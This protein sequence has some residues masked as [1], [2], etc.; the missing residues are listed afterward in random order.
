MPIPSEMLC[1]FFKDSVFIAMYNKAI[2]TSIG[3]KSKITEKK[4]VSPEIPLT[5]FPVLHISVLLCMKYDIFLFYKCL[6]IRERAQSHRLSFYLSQM[7][8]FSYFFVSVNCFPCM[9]RN[10]VPFHLGYMVIF[11]QISMLILEYGSIHLPWHPNVTTSLC[12]LLLVTP[13]AFYSSQSLNLLLWL[14]WKCQQGCLPSPGESS[15]L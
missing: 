14:Q 12:H 2:S 11:S 6:D 5:C 15:W 9:K 7:G 1:D 13:W 3:I 10:T 8:S 4:D